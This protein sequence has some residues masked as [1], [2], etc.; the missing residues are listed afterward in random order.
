MAG[1]G[2]TVQIATADM[3][4]LSRRGARSHRGGGTFSRSVVLHRSLQAL[5]DVLDRSDPRLTRGMSQEMH[6]LI[7]RLLPEPWALKVFEVEQMST[8]LARVPAFA[9]AAADAGV[10]PD[11]LLT[12]VSQLNFSEKMA[13]VDHALQEQAPAA[14]A[15]MPEEA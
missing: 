4:F 8:L 12:L 9:A 14:A 10:D 3:V 1:K 6:R 15:A 11:A 7:A 2:T 5:R 13:L